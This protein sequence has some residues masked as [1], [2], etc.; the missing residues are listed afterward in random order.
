MPPKGSSKEKKLTPPLTEKDNPIQTNNINARGITA[1]S[2]ITGLILAVAH[3]F[4]VVYE[5]T[6]LNHLAAS[7]TAFMLVPS[8]IAIIFFILIYNSIVNA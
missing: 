3:T 7:F 2:I 4:W 1:R 8:V 6:A 5:E